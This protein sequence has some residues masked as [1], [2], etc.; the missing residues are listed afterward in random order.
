MTNYI[1]HRKTADEVVAD[2][3]AQLEERLAR[4]FGNMTLW[5]EHAA[6]L[7]RAYR[8]MK[9]EVETLRLQQQ[10]DRQTI[11][12]YVAMLANPPSPTSGEPAGGAG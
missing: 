10:T 9:G 12:N 1:Q 8:E 6:T 2:L 3:D 7:L 4:D 5:H 11:A